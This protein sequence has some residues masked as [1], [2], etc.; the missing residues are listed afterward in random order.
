MN[1]LFSKKNILTVP[2]LLSIIRILLIPIII[3]LYI[4][5]QDYYGAI[6]VIILSGLTDVADGIIARKFNMVSDFGKII[7]PIADKL[8]QASLII[9]L[10]FKYKLMI[11]IICLFI[12]REAAMSAMGIVTFIKN[13]CVCSSKWYGKVNTVVLYCVTVL[14]IL[15]P[16]IEQ[17]FANAIILFTSCVMIIT[18]LMYMRFYKILLTENPNS[19]LAADG[20]IIA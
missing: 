19:K 1:K 13:N 4:S 20:N 16:Q 8:T 18:F 3:Y 11:Y 6:G 12:L 9:C 7:D 10:A 14:L 5:K 15:F 17:R 2:N